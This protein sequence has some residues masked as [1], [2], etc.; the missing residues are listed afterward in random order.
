MVLGAQS[1]GVGHSALQAVQEVFG[2]AVPVSGQ[3]V[4]VLQDGLSA[5]SEKKKKILLRLGIE[6]LE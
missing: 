6:A 5:Q 2:Q 3:A 1:V 4:P